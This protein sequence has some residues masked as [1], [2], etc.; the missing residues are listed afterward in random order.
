MGGPLC[1]SLV[2]AAGS[3]VSTASPR[4]PGVSLRSTAGPARAQ[5]AVPPVQPRPGRVYNLPAR[6]PGAAASLALLP[7]SGCESPA[8]RP[9]DSHLARARA[10]IHVALHGTRSH[11]SPLTLIPL[12]HTRAHTHGSPPPG[13]RAHTF[14]L[15]P[16]SRPGALA[17]QGSAG[18]AG[19]SAE[20]THGLPMADLSFI[21]DSVAFPEKEEDDEEEEEGVEWGYEEGNPPRVRRLALP[22]PRPPLFPTWVPGPFRGSRRSGQSGRCPRASPGARPW[23]RQRLAPAAGGRAQRLRW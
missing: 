9:K 4:S 22:A 5:G 18:T 16:H 1:V 6:A 20:G 7:G 17:L 21:E 10:R 11:S 13:T 3:A 23:S 14:P 19:E 8:R 12:A 15:T 2:G